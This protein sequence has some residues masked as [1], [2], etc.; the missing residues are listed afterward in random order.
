MTSLQGLSGKVIAVSGAGSGIGLATAHYLARRGCLLSLM[1]INAKA[2]EDAAESVRK[3]TNTK[4]VTTTGDVSEDADVERWIT[5]T[6]SKLGRLDGAANVAGIFVES[7]AR[8]GI[9]SME[10][11]IW[12]SVIG[13][14]LTGMMYCL[15]AQLKVISHGGSIVNASSV[16][17]LLGSSQF[18]AY[19]TSKHG[20]I[21]LSKCAAREAGDREVRV[22]AIVP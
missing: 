3:N 15:R 14:N 1:D 11:K 18:P 2:V 19:S 16:A 9:A 21:G 4:V 22:N 12:N 17:G 10:D 8:G 7:T 20:V 13:V 6:V 5:S